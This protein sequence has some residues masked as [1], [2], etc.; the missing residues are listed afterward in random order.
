MTTRTTSNAQV[1][2]LRA[3]ALNQILVMRR[4][5]G[6][7]MGLRDGIRANKVIDGNG[8]NFHRAGQRANGYADGMAREFERIMTSYDRT[9][10]ADLTIARLSSL[11][12]YMPVRYATISKLIQA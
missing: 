8:N 11:T 7:V 6:V 2:E 5:A 1:M 10:D 12:N 3:Q 9:N 4:I